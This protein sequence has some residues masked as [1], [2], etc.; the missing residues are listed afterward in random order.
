MQLANSAMQRFENVS[1]TPESS[2]AHTGSESKSQCLLMQ[3][4]A[5]GM[6]IAGGAASTDVTNNPIKAI[7]SIPDNGVTIVNAIQ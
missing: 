5:P 6:P 3:G 1:A 4:I 2:T 7:N